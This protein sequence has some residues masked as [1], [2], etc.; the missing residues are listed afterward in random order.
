VTDGK[1]N[2]PTAATARQTWWKVRKDVTAQCKGPSPALDRTNNN[3]VDTQKQ[4]S[5][6][7]P[8]SPKP[9][10]A[11]SA[12]GFDPD[13]VDQEATEP[14]FRLATPRARPPTADLPKL[15]PRRTSSKPDQGND[16]DTAL[17]QLTDR[18]R[19]RSLPMP[20]IPTAEDE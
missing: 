3:S 14:E 15:P 17:R 13:D 9:R 11:P 6:T 1:G 10:V 5:P 12:N 20:Q 19:A 4:S 16:Y 2:P 7:M 8:V 18:A